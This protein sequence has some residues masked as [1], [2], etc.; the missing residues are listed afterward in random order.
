M[1]KKKKKILSV[2]EHT[3]KRDLK[4]L[5]KPGTDGGRGCPRPRGWSAAP[6]QRRTRRQRRS[7][8]AARRTRSP[9]ALLRERGAGAAAAA[10]R[11]GKGT[12]GK[13]G[14]GGPAQHAAPRPGAPP[15]SIV[16]GAAALRS[17]RAEPGRTRE[18]P[19]QAGQERKAARERREPTD[20]AP[21]VP[22][23]PPRRRAPM[24]SQ[25]GAKALFHA[26]RR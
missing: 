23:P 20:S 4:N 3:G 10:G 12:E 13:G 21:P 14:S 16:R 17:R 1:I 8:G 11:E 9:R 5:K 6:L 25:R 22:V 19:G 18:P 7:P 15:L 2:F 24:A 26:G